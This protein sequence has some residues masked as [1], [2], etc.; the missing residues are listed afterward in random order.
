MRRVLFLTSMGFICT[1][2]S[3][4]ALLAARSFE[5]V[6]THAMK[7]ER[8]MLGNPSTADGLCATVY[9]QYMSLGGDG[10]AAFY[11]CVD[12]YASRGVNSDQI[13]LK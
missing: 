8:P 9:R 12:S 2:I 1:A 7:P 5:P 6:N 13:R 4:L 10:A 3:G 11:A